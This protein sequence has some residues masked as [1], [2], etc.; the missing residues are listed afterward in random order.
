MDSK[1]ILNKL[2]EGR[3]YRDIDVSSFERR[4]E[5]NGDKTVEGY[6]TTFSQPYELYRDSWNGY[7]YIVREQVDP[8][9]FD[10]TDMS[11]V[12]MQYNHE[13]RVFARGSNG[14]LELD[15]DSHGL[16]IRAKLGGTEIG[17]QL[18]EEIS[19]GY[20]TKMSFG[21]RVSEDR[22]EETEKRD[23]ES[24]VTT[25][26]VLRTILKISKLYDVS[27]VSLPAND[28][29]SISARNFGEGVIA[30]VKK[31]ILAREA[32]ER[33]KQKIRILTEVS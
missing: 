14:T 22:R 24:G 1:T 10:D 2:D 9:A 4:A 26:T 23:V 29:T 6:A 18:Y 21:F 8:A 16:H 28:A 15:P 12:I 3:Q 31:E 33:R 25:V 17:R 13:G 27:A 11:D 5:E 19:G 7:V 30:E 20:T 32:R